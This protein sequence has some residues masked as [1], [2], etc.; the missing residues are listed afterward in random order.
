MRL[1]PLV[2]LAILAIGCGDDPTAPQSTA[3]DSATEAAPC[4]LEACYRAILRPEE[5]DSVTACVT[6]GCGANEQACVDDAAKKHS[7]EMAVTSFSEGCA[8]KDT[9]CG[10]RLAKSV[11]TSEFSLLTDTLRAKASDCL[12]QDCELVAECYQSALQSAGCTR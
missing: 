8:A 4:S 12:A 5:V 9:A 11:C 6:V 1:A 10:G 3:T 2:A 7:S